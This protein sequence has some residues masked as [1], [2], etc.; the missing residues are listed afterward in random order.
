[1]N[2]LLHLRTGLGHF[3]DKLQTLGIRTMVD[4]EQPEYFYGTTAML[5]AAVAVELELAVSY[6][7]ALPDK[8]DTASYKFWRQCLPNCRM[9]C[10]QTETAALARR[11]QC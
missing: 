5:S 11:F 4:H 9:K 1:M 10:A 8:H 2:E 7:A 6:P 3:N